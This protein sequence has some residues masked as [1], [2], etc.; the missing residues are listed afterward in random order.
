MSSDTYWKERNPTWREVM[1][2]SIVAVAIFG[3]ALLV[4]T[5]Y[6]PKAT[7]YPIS[8]H[9]LEASVTGQQSSES[10]RSDR[11]GNSKPY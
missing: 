11:V 6:D 2:E 5:L 3:A 1:A 10:T 8:Q 7:S 4:S 9:S